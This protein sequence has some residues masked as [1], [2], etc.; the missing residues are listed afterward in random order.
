[1]KFLSRKNIKLISVII[2]LMAVV[3]LSSRGADNPC[4]GTVLWA[5]SP[6]LKTFRI[7][8]SGIQGFFQFLGSI[9]DLKNENEKL[10][11]ENQQLLAEIANLKD[12]KGE[13]ELLRKEINLVPRKK[14]DLEASF[15]IAQDSLGSTGMFLIDK[16]RNKGIE[17][18]MAVVVSNGIL[19]GKVSEVFSDTARVTLITDQSSAVNGEISGSGARGIVKGTYGLG[20]ALDMISQAEVVQEGDTVITSGLGGDD[21]RGLYIGKIGEV[22]QSTDKLFQQATIFSLADLTSLRVVFVVKE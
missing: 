3:I 22:G 7:F 16:G 1:M 20:V 5:T 4:K 15:V 14:Y 9:G 6:F 17:E 12:I 19:V 8:S 21:P 13:N 10:V 18:G 11:G 2:I